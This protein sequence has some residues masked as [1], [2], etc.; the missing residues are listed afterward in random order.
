MSKELPP[1]DIN[2]ANRAQLLD[3]PGIGPALADRILDNRPY[4]TLEDLL[5]VKGIGSQSLDSL[6][7]YLKADQPVTEAG[8]TAAPEPDPTQ[9][10][11]PSD[12]HTSEEQPES[13]PVK[14]LLKLPSSDE[15]PPEQTYS[16][17]Q[18][19]WLVIL[20]SIFSII[21]T[22]ALILG[23]LTGINR[24]LQYAS[25][26]AQTDLERQI[27]ALEEQHDILADE[28]T[29]LRARMDNL[30]TISGRMEDLES[31]LNS[32]EAQTGELENRL[33][34][35]EADTERFRNFLETLSQNLLEVLQTNEV[36]Q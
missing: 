3:L 22:T 4:Q 19:L 28:L 1:L 15:K 2:S 13:S 9:A 32:L 31:D 5:E 7:P 34:I 29:G 27:S 26:T 33:D 17:Y 20:S 6:R 18:T 8:A 25:R 23:V 21:L 14:A 24:T 36:D 11:P 10:A 35:V 30:D 12:Q 16:R